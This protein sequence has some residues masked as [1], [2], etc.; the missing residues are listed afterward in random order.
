MM[1]LARKLAKQGKAVYVVF[2]TYGMRDSMQRWHEREHGEVKG[3][4]FETAQMLPELDWWTLTLRNAHPNC[5]V[6]VDHA[7]IE[8]HFRIPEAAYVMMHAFD[9]EVV[10]K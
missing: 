1:E 2:H 6:L 9:R 7:A 5:V 8:D 3:I 4:R 10:K